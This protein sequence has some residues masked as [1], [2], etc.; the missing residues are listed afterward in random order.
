V[1]CVRC[2]PTNVTFWLL[3]KSKRETTSCFLVS[4]NHLAKKHGRYQMQTGIFTGNF[5]SFGFRF[6]VLTAVMTNKWQNI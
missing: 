2:K 1:E 3:A 5:W 6:F 4:K